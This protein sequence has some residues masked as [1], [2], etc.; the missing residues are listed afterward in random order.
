MYTLSEIYV[1]SRTRILHSEHQS[2]EDC[3]YNYASVHFDPTNIAVVW[4][5]LYSPTSESFQLK[6]T[7]AEQ[8]LQVDMPERATQI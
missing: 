6:R 5:D 1:G 4:R 7:K 8:Y 2:V 3:D